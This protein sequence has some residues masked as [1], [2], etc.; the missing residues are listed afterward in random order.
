MKRTFKS[1]SFGCRVNQ[2]EK[3]E[4]DS[5]L[6][7]LGFSY[8]PDGPSLFIINSCAVTDKAE[9]EVRQL[10]YQ[11]RK[12]NPKAKIVVTGCAATN[13]LK[14]KVKIPEA[15]IIIDNQNKEYM[16]SLL[17]KKIAGKNKEQTVSALSDKY[18]NS[19]RHLLKIQ[20]GCHRFCSYCIVPY[21]RGLPK[22]ISI[23]RLINT[24][25]GFDKNIKEVIL[26]AINT[27]AYGYDNKE[28]FTE[29]IG[30]ILK[31]TNI[32]RI[33]YGSLHPWSI[34]ED[35]LKFYKANKNSDR[36]VNFFHVP[37]QSGS[38]RILSLMKRGYTGEEFLNKI[39]DLSSVKPHAF[40]GTDIIVGYLDETDKDFQDTYDLLEKSAIS[41]F[42]IFRY[43]KREHTAA[44]YLAKR[45]NEPS[46]QTKTKR[47]KALAELGKRKYETFVNGHVGHTFSALFLENEKDGY[48]ECL[49]SNQIPALIKADRKLAGQIKNVKILRYKNGKI[50]GKIA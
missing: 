18:V 2:A 16:A 25:N 10:I 33:S 31:K 7:K 6:L 36:L 14:M 45:L 5:Q 40:I 17:D 39:A 15:D 29:L 9:R 21:L 23:N 35:Y 32:A 4:L 30:A 44:Y 26:T 37:L 41:K 28:T 12:K 43:S 46:V 24:I 34:K 11:T 8:S 19:G 22:S 47:A 42:H 27:E 49:L 20:D 3:E 50:F 1:V 38:N 48:R 13:W